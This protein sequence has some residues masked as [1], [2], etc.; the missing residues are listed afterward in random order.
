MSNTVEKLEPAKGKIKR[1]MAWE[2]I[3]AGSFVM[4]REKDNLY[5][6]LGTARTASGGRQPKIKLLLSLRL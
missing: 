2:M 6:D 1:W 3:L 4:S 5:Q